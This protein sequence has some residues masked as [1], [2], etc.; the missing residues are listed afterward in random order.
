MSISAKATSLPTSITSALPE[1]YK[2][3]DIEKP[4]KDGVL[5]VLSVLTHIGDISQEAWDD[6]F[7]Y[8]SSN[9]ETYTIL[10]IIDE[11]GDICATGSLIIE[12]KLYNDFRVSIF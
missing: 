12:R 1:N 6:R 7:D 2:I 10:C 3:R 9:P 8:I 11:K 5:S 4:D